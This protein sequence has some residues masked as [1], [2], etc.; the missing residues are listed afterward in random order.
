MGKIVNGEQEQNVDSIGSYAHDVAVLMWDNLNDIRSVIPHHDTSGSSHLLFRDLVATGWIGGIG[1]YPSSSVRDIESM[2]S[3]M[4]DHPESERVLRKKIVAIQN[5]LV[6]E[7]NRASIQYDA[8]KSEMSK[9]IKKY[10]S[11][12]NLRPKELL[13]IDLNVSSDAKLSYIK[14]I[15]FKCVQYREMAFSETPVFQLAQAVINLGIEL[16]KQH[17]FEVLLKS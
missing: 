4:P 12:N 13:E 9:I 6:I 14:N 1:K 16:R 10:S 3:S 15:S 5:C 17:N 11:L 7:R 2:R 8:Y